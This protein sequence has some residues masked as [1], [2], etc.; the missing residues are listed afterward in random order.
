M[1]RGLLFPATKA[2][3]LL[4]LLTKS[5]TNG[6]LIE[7]VYKILQGFEVNAPS[8]FSLEELAQLVVKIAPEIAVT[9]GLEV[10]VV[11]GM[12]AEIA[13]I[14]VGVILAG[15]FVDMLRPFI[16][17]KL[18]SFKAK[19]LYQTKR[20]FVDE[21]KQL[22][23]KA[24]SLYVEVAYK[25]D[26]GMHGI[27]YGIRKLAEKIIGGA[28]DPPG[29]PPRPDPEERKDPECDYISPGGTGKRR[30]EVGYG[31][32]DEHKFHLEGG[33]PGYIKTEGQCRKRK[34]GN[35]E[36]GNNIEEKT[37]EWPDMN[38]ENIRRGDPSIPRPSNFGL[39]T[40][41][42]V[43][44]GGAAAA[45]AYV[46][47]KL[48]DETG[49]ICDDDSVFYGKL[50]SISNKRDFD[51]Y[52][53]SQE[54]CLSTVTGELRSETWEQQVINRNAL[55]LWTNPADVPFTQQPK[56]TETSPNIQG[57][58]STAMSDKT[59]PNPS[60]ANGPVEAGNS[61]TVAQDIQKDSADGIVPKVDPTEKPFNQTNPLNETQ[62]VDPTPAADPPK[63]YIDGSF[64]YG[65]EQ[66][67]KDYADYMEKYK[68]KWENKDTIV[69]P[70]LDIN[71]TTKTVPSEPLSSDGASSKKSGDVSST[72]VGVAL[73]TVAAVG[74][75][76]NYS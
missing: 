11:I 51:A 66:D 16:D 43:G 33:P 73:A 5:S 76:L 69:K 47:A 65:T 34:K 52:I 1:Q 10:A 27:D 22:E 26:Q 45:A 3:Y 36:K 71:T 61:T 59:E 75:I 2:D 62:K 46:A 21:W 15:A 6:Q 64:M 63:V 31:P 50:R 53:K 28:G 8:T 29:P 49:V 70:D 74:V 24:L 7:Y 44:A 37:Y 41:M 48:K 55:G 72:A 54:G 14:L 20:L 9:E 23:P 4:S 32:T 12:I 57:T 18:T 42:V 40:T 56:T 38:D 17:E 30:Y 67:K 13:P 60:G 58:N 19:T 25:I 39:T 68:Q 35:D